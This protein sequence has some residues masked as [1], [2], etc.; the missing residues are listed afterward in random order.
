MS[1]LAVM[2]GKPVG[3]LITPSWPIFDKRE[4]ETLLDV[5]H[6]GHWSFLGP[7][8]KRFEQAFA[9]YTGAEYAITATNGTHTLRLLLEAYNIGPGDEVIVPALTWQ[10]TAASVLDANALPVLVDVDE[11]T[12]TIDP[13][14]VEAAITSR[15]RAIIP[16][17][18]YGRMAD[19]DAIMDIAAR[20]NLIVI[21]DAA[22]QHGS[23]WRGVNA[24]LV[25]NAGS[26]SLQSSKGLNAGEGGLI[27]TNDRRVNDLVQSMKICGRPWYKGGPSMQSGNYRM[28]DFQS[29]IG[30][31]Q[32]S[33]LDE[34]NRLREANAN[35]LEAAMANF[36][37]LTPLKRNPNVTFQ[38][39][40]SWSL[41][42]DKAQW[43]GVSK[44]AFLKAVSAEIEDCVGVMGTYT[45]L[46]HS[47]L[48]RPLSKKTHRMSE[49][50]A[51]AINPAQYDLPVCD[52]IFEDLAVNFA[53]TILLMDD[54]GNQK[55]LDV[56]AK[57][58]DNIDELR[59][60]DKEYVHVYAD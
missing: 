57:L 26:F 35:K 38:T 28:T 16:V 40:Y 15:T 24:G 9:E 56:F 55:L 60:F 46:H 1:N 31:I 2:G 42:Y 44:W 39:Y 36:P 6:S 10:A 58:R 51:K 5:L 27:I 21:E 37:G 45:P 7:Y 14:A 19:M 49:E 8:E 53:H 48:Y 11:A 54:A 20:Y 30:L 59:T 12:F 22:H 33:R 13:K 18:I 25:G 4:E 52:K 47:T 34:Q 32:L 17:H 23:R 41:V 29:A 43:G 50:Y 3:A